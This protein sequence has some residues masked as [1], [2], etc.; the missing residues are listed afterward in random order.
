[1][2]IKCNILY[3][4]E[5]LQ[6]IR[7]KAIDNYFSVRDDWACI[8]G[9]RNL[10]KFLLEWGMSAVNYTVAYKVARIWE[11][12]SIS[13]NQKGPASMVLPPSAG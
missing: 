2:Q 7:I 4:N 6:N 11:N 8:L 9:E 12:S 3:V 5:L 13:K 10:P 1:M